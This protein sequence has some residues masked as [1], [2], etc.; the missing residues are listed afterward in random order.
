MLSNAEERSRRIKRDCEPASA[1]INRLLVTWIKAVS[2]ECEERK[3][4]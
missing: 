3:P 1:A 2:V 4:D